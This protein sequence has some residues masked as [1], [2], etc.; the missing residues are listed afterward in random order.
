MAMEWESK[1]QRFGGISPHLPPAASSN[2]KRVTF[3]ESCKT[4]DSCSAKKVKSSDDNSI[5]SH[6]LAVQPLGNYLLN[7]VTPT[8]KQ[9]GLG[10]LVC[11]EDEIIMQILSQYLSVP[12]LSSL[13]LVSRAFYVFSHEE[14]I[15]RNQTL[16]TYA[17]NF[18]FKHNWR[19]TYIYNRLIHSR[20][21][22]SDFDALNET[23]E[24]IRGMPQRI[25]IPAF[26]SDYF[27]HLHH[28]SS[29]NLSQYYLNSNE[30][31]QRID[32]TNLTVQQFVE[33]FGIPNKPVILTNLVPN[34]PAFNN[35]NSRGW[36]MD[37]LLRRFGSKEFKVGKYSM[38]LAD[39]FTY[40]Q[41]TQEESPLYLFDSAF[42]EKFPSMLEDYGVADYFSDD[43]FSVLADLEAFEGYND[44]CEDRGEEKQEMMNNERKKAAL[45]QHNCDNNSADNP[46][47]VDS[48]RVSFA[49]GT[50]RPSYRWILI[51]P[52]RS[53]STFHKVSSIL[54]IF[55]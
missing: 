31:I 6:P 27:F 9:L 11:L 23:I 34:W 10:S 50:M 43:L 49:H 25:E 15:W 13:M 28:C 21:V 51:G 30:N 48:S 36:T 46:S 20:A 38:K 29:V 32:A 42:G 2:K 52:A 17:G 33:R 47:A 35:S 41:Q 24:Y 8:T 55:V 37:N 53:G 39:Y 5:I 44:G 19:I 1:E 26:Y 3:D 18:I 14:E 16:N 4:V 45:Q 22:G 54:C 7:P 12:A 40:M